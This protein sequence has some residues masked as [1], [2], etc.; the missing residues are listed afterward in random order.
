MRMFLGWLLMKLLDRD[1]K[2]FWFANYVGGAMLY[3]GEN[4]TG[5]RS[6]DYEEP[7]QAFGTF[8][9]PNGAATARE[10]GAYVEYDYVIHMDGDSCPFDE[11]AAIWLNNSTDEDPDFKV[12]KIAELRTYVAVAVKQLR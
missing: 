1:K 7:Q 5:E 3:D 11:F 2:E 4:P 8:S 6:H 12:T 9:V 10:F